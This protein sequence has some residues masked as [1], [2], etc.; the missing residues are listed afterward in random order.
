MLTDVVD[1]LTTGGYSM[2]APM[3]AVL[4]AAAGKTIAMSVASL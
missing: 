4:M 1:E 3:A 2:L